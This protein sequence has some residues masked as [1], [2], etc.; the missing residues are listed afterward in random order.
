MSYTIAA[1]STGSAISAIGIIRLTGDDCAQISEKVFTLNSQAPL[2]QSP[3]R[4]LMLG[5]LHDKN[6]RVIDQCMAVYSRG[7]HS[8]TGED[9]RCQAC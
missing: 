6:G 4:K 3:D 9:C 5:S 8:Y 7:P 1:V 2:S